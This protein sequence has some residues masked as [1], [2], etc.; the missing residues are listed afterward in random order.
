MEEQIAKRQEIIRLLIQKARWASRVVGLSAY[1]WEEGVR[2]E[3]PEMIELIGE[4][5]FQHLICYF[6]DLKG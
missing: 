4:K 3:V 2:E 6:F 5:D 1:E